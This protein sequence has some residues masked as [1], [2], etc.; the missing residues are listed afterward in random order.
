MQFA[1]IQKQPINI[2]G[3][4]SIPWF[5]EG[6]GEEVLASVGVRHGAAHSAGLHLLIR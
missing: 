6:Q 3:K 5:I 1:D 2:Y 4:P